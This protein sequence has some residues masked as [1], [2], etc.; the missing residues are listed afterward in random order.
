MSGRATRGE[1]GETSETGDPSEIC[2]AFHGAGTGGR[3]RRNSQSAWGV[4]H[5]ETVKVGVSPW[6]G[7][8]CSR[9][10]ELAFS[11]FMSAE[12]QNDPGQGL[13]PISLA[14]LA[15]MSYNFGLAR[16][17]DWP[18]VV[19]NFQWDGVLRCFSGIS[20]RF[21]ARAKYPDDSHPIPH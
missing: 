17:F 19:W 16:F 2:S 15:A 7:T 20:G 4:E 13:T 8:K 1:T 18:W 11:F 9:P 3:A 5:D 12:T 10:G 14:Y 6:H 21:A